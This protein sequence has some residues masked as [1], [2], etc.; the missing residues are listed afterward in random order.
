MIFQNELFSLLFERYRNILSF[1][2]YSSDI[3]SK[4]SSNILDNFSRGRRYLRLRYRLIL[5]P[6]VAGDIQK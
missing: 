2:K 3:R 1:C 4:I 5:T 6:K